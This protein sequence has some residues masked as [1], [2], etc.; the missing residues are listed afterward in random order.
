MNQPI[1]FSAGTSQYDNCPT[2]LEVESDEEFFDWLLKARSTRKGQRYICAPMV[3]GPHDAPEKHPGNNHW[4]LKRNELARRFLAFDIDS[5]VIPA[6]LEALIEYVTRWRSIVYTTSSHTPEA[7][8][9]RLILVVNED[10]EPAEAKALCEV[11]ELEMRMA[12]G[13]GFV[14]DQSVYRGAQPVYTPTK[15]ATTW[16]SEEP[17]VDVSRYRHLITS[18]L[19]KPSGKHQSD[20]EPNEITPVGKRNE[21]LLSRVGLWRNAGLPEGEILQMANSLNETAFEEP[22]DCDEVASICARYAHQSKPALPNPT[23]AVP[24][25][26]ASSWLPNGYRP[27]P[28]TAPPPREY[29]FGNTITPGTLSVL[30]GSGGVSKTMLAMQI[31][32]ASACGV[33]VGEIQVAEGCS[34]LLLGE[35]DDAER[36]RRLGGICSHF[37]HSTSRVENRVL[38]IG[39]AGIDIRL[40]QKVEANSHPTVLGEK[41][42]EVAQSHAAQCGVPLRF[43]V[44]D[45]ARLVLGGDPNNAEDVTQLTRVLTNIARTTGASVLLIAHSPK[46]VLSKAGNEINAADIAGSSAFVDNGRTAFMAYGM[47]EE[48]AKRHYIPE[49]DRP[50][51]VRVQNVKANYAPSGGGWWFK[52]VVVQGWDIAVLEHQVLASTAEFT[53]TKQANLQRK[54]L[55]H[56]RQNPGSSKRAVRDRAGRKGIFGISDRELMA[57]VDRMVDEGLLD[58]RP[59]TAEERKRL[60]IS[61]Q[62]REIL[63]AQTPS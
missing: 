45:H 34:L 60:G 17:P 3:C 11:L 28:T 15:G 39:A 29:V 2:Q 26:K 53:S 48:E 63:V 9:A 14:F 30:G 54:I 5:I 33:T 23:T 7:P 22:L 59:P 38:C 36:D 49:L 41:I 42:I 46:S 61:G 58:A 27:I 20:P 10:L 51:W 56:I 21:V 43:I 18:K 19:Q 4:R 32:A 50:S 1:R 52:R 55:D 16:I 8:R 44:I 12:L 25:P 62:V 37:K 57:T 47:R 35:E 40:T 13:T 31:C 24:Q 6:T